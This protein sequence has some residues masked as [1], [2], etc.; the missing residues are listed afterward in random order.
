MTLDIHRIWLLLTS[1]YWVMWEVCPG[2]NRSNWGAIVIGGR[3]H[4]EVPKKWT[5]TKVF[6]EWMRRLERCI[7]TDGDYVG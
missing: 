7:E 5:L 6:L 2:A 4:F 3:W 1:I